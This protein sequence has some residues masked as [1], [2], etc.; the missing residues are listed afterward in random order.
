MKKYQVEFLMPG[1]IE[2][3]GDDEQ[4]VQEFVENV[5]TEQLLRWLFCKS[6]DDAKNKIQIIAVKKI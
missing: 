4:D 5:G 2:V 6:R 3:E 1:R